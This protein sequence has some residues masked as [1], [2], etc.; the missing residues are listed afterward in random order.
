MWDLTS[1]SSFACT[2]SFLQTDDLVFTF[3]FE[4]VSTMG[5][6]KTWLVEGY[7]CWTSVALVIVFCFL[8]RAKREKNWKLMFESKK[9]SWMFF[10]TYALERASE[11]TDLTFHSLLLGVTLKMTSW[12]VFCLRNILDWLNWM[13]CSVG[14][15]WT[16]LA[17]AWLWPASR[18]CIIFTL[19]T[20][21][22][23]YILFS[24]FRGF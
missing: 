12:K 10:Y 17:S 6:K 3:Q 5:G 8:N 24:F 14:F 21:K 16:S 20:C 23:M 9:K 4:V 2:T 1:E 15:S 22:Y 11:Q 7:I 13:S 19:F 18:T